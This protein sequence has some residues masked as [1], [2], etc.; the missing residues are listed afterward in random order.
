MPHYGDITPMMPPAADDAAFFIYCRRCH[1]DA[2][3]AAFHFAAMPY[4]IDDY[5]DVYAYATFAITLISFA[6][7]PLLPFY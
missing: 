2:F 3:I 6:A 1:D 5:F 7:M 4:A